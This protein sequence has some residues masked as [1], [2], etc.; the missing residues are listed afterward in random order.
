[1]CNLSQGLVETGIAK[2][3]AEGRAEGIAEGR[4]EGRND[5]LIELVQSGKITI[6]D[7]AEMTGMSVEEFQ[8]MMNDGLN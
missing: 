7:A 5:T 6:E 3:R 4:A 2:G 1:M 8:D